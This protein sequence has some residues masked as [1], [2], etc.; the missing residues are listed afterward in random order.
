VERPG[1][2][3]RLLRLRR[4]LAVRQGGFRP[5]RKN[6]AADCHLRA[7]GVTEDEGQRILPDPFVAEQSADR[8]CQ[9]SSLLPIE[10]ADRDIDAGEYLSR[11]LLAP[12]N[13]DRPRLEKHDGDKLERLPRLGS[14]DTKPFRDSP[15]A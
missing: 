5:E 1:W 3:L 13:E 15:T 4:R 9:P 6:T 7:G 11:Y 8:S 12:M 2:A 10:S 14:C